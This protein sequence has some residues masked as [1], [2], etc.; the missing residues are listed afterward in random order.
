MSIG[1]DFLSFIIALEEFACGSAAL[2]LSISVTEA[3]NHL[4]YRYGSRDQHKYIEALRKGEVFGAVA[5]D[6]SGFDTN[7]SCQVRNASGNSETILNAVYPFVPNAPLADMVVIFAKTDAGSDCSFI[8]DRHT[9]G[10]T[11][12]ESAP[13]MGLQSL[14]GG[15]LELKDVRI[16]VDNR[17]G[18]ENQGEAVF[19]GLEM[20]TQIAIGAIAVGISQ[21]ALEE[22]VT[23]AKN[24]IQFGKPLARMEATRNKIAN[25]ASG[26]EAA[27]LLV[28]RAA[29]LIDQ[30]KHSA[31][32]A[33]MAKMIASD[34]AVEVCKEAVQIHG[35]Y[36]Y[37][38]D[39]PVERLYRDALFTQIY[40]TTN[41][42][43]RFRIAEQVYRKIK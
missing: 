31:Y 29:A 33:A 38:K 24:R 20:R 5:L 28:Y 34:L 17:L 41:A 42:T 19:E 18:G 26:I 39:Y 21:L 15:R 37:V 12:A 1:D 14:A 43:Q 16:R 6:V 9:A 35:G 13:L 11:V 40:N 25:M 2:A 30:G 36:G 22:A 32:S 8:L 4:L 23:H 10:I 3:V 7:A 27:R